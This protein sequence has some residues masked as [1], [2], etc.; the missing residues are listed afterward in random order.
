[1]RYKNNNPIPDKKIKEVIDFF[2]NSKLPVRFI[3][4]RTNLSQRTVYYI[5][6]ELAPLLCWRQPDEADD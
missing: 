5:K 4:L 3:A 6:N 2:L 1:M